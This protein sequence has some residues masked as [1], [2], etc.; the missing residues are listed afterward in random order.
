M[1]T[2]HPEVVALRVVNREHGWTH[3]VRV[4]TEVGQEFMHLID[5]VLELFGRPIALPI[6]RTP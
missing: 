4:Q 1:I 3:T 2:R 5:A 6:R